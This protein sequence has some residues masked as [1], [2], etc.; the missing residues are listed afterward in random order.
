MQAHPQRLIETPID[1]SG[2]QHLQADIADGALNDQ[3]AVRKEGRLVHRGIDPAAPVASL[4]FRN[5]VARHIP[6]RHVTVRY[7]NGLTGI[8]LALLS[9]QIPDFVTQ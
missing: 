3:R 4:H 8:T 5:Q 6:C 7:G 1:E 2:D 9:E